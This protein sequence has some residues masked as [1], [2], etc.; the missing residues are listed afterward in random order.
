MISPLSKEQADKLVDSINAE[1][2]P[3]YLAIRICP[4]G[5]EYCFVCLGL[6][7]KKLTSL[8]ADGQKH[9]G[10]VMFSISN[11]EEW[12]SIVEFMTLFVYRMEGKKK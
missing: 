8:L 9:I 11:K 1:I 2:P 6:V 4:E 12:E 10:K 5:K 3:E 7:D